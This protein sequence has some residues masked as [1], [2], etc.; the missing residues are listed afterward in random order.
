MAAI[1]EVGL[2]EGSRGRGVTPDAAMQRCTDCSSFEGPA[3]CWFGS[4]RLGSMWQFTTTT[5]LIP[6]ELDRKSGRWSRRLEI[7]CEVI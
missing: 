5:T 3:D 2:S 6:F 1:D 7:E 4:L